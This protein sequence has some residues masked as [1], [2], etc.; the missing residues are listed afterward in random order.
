APPEPRSRALLPRCRA[1]L[2]PSR[3]RSRGRARSR[4]GDARS[5]LRR[6]VGAKVAQVRETPTLD[7]ED[8]R[9]CKRAAGNGRGPATPS[10]LHRCR[11]SR[12]WHE[13]RNDRSNPF[14]TG[15]FE[16][17]NSI[18]RAKKVWLPLAANASCTTV[19]N[20]CTKQ[21]GIIKKCPAY[22]T[23]PTVVTTVTD[24]DTAV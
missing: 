22:A 20:T 10:M 11:A 6:A 5:R 17:P 14:N 9:A 15:R 4:Q 1:L 21:S 2:S 16:M 23:T 7:G 24:L 12:P 18:V 13:P 8:H 19:V 3:R